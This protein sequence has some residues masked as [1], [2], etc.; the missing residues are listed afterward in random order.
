MPFQQ[1]PAQEQ[2]SGIDPENQGET[3]KGAHIECRPNLQK[4]QSKENNSMTI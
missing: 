4:T 1:A 3:N 2:K